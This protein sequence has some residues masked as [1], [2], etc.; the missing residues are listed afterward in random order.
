MRIDPDYT[1]DTLARLVQINS[2]NPTLA[3]GA[4]GE[5]EIA[6]FIAGSLRGAGLSAEIFEPEPGRCTVLGRLAGAGGGRTLMLNAH[7][8]TV[9]VAGMAE[10]FSGAIRDG[11]LYGRGSFDMKGSLAA[12]M[13]AA[14]ALADSGVPLRGD[15][16]IAAVADEEYGSLGTR[17]LIGRI[18]CDGAIVTEPTALDTCLAHKG[19][20]WIEVAVAGRAAHGSKFEL[21]IDA[22]MK[23][24]AFLHGLGRLERELRAR[25]PHPLVGPPSLHAALLNGGSGLSTYA[26]SATVQIERRTIPGETEAQ[27]VAEIQAICDVLAAADPDFHA[28]VRPFFVRD[29]FEVA[30]DAPVVRAVDCAAARVLGHAPAHIGDTPWMDAALLQAAGVETVVFGAAGAGAHA[31]VEWVSVDSVVKLAEILAEAALDYC[32]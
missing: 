4:P 24:G 12:C 5:R 28:T 2:I 11:K 22:N 32:G 23:M 6:A 21:G 30:A 15:L 7:C 16:L 8:D 3:P 10:P 20:L 25:P 29:P 13:A 18:R 14:K 17:D 1:R 27:A 9:D 26:A 31:D 19:Y